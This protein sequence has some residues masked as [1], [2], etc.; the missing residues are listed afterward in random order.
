FG[1]AML[2]GMGWKPPK[3]GEDEL[4]IL[5]ERPALLG[6]GAKARPTA[7]AS[8]AKGHAAN[9]KKA[10]RKY[11]PLVKKD[12]SGDVADDGKDSAS[13]RP[14]SG[15]GSRR[16]SRSRSPQDQSDPSRRDRKREYRDRERDY[17]DRESG[18]ARD[19][20][21]RDSIR[22]GGRDDDRRREDRERDSTR[23]YGRHGSS[24]RRDDRDY[25]GSRRR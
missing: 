14:R 9:W 24:K 8:G 17:R 11:V 23:D 3:K 18:R 16:N 22:E 25:D 7:Q 6:L 10:E 20:H 2:R 15:R 12:R 5:A 1:M 21:N 13:N 4:W 19:G